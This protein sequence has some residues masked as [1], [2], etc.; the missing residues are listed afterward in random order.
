MLFDGKLVFT[1]FGFLDLILSI[2]VSLINLLGFYS[3][4]FDL[5]LGISLLI[6]LLSN[7]FCVEQQEEEENLTNLEKLGF[8]EFDWWVK[9]KL[10]VND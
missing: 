5:L 6:K 9:S 8:G 7:S 10:E 4:C 3:V 1:R 2:S